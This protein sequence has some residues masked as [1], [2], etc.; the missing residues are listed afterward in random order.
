MS[1]MMIDL[2]LEILHRICI[3]L[4]SE[5]ALAFLH[6]SPSIH[7]ACN[8]WTVWRDLIA[9][10]PSF[11][12]GFST[13]TQYAWKRYVVADARASRLEEGTC[14]RKAVEQYLPQLLA[15]KYTGAPSIHAEA[16]YNLCHPLI[17]NAVYPRSLVRLAT[18]SNPRWEFMTNPSSPFSASDWQSAQAAAFCFASR[19][20]SD[21][22]SP[23]DPE[24]S[25]F[26]LGSV[27][28]LLS[29]TEQ[30]KNGKAVAMQHALANAVVGCFCSELR[31]ALSG[32]RTISENFDGC[33]YPPSDV[34]I[35]LKDCMAL[36]VP[37]STR[38]TEM[39]GTCHV[40]AMTTPSFFTED[41]W[42][43][44]FSTRGDWRSVYQGVGGYSDEAVKS[45]R[46]ASVCE[47]AVE[48]VVRFRVVRTHENGDFVLR[49]NRFH[50]PTE[51]HV[52]TMLVERKTGR[53]T[54]SLDNSCKSIEDVSGSEVRNAV[55]TPFGIVH[56]VRPGE[57]MWLWKSRWSR[58]VEPGMQ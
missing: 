23:E 55:I 10:N 50:T 11:P 18:D 43:G 29:T 17:S 54:A 12:R 8:D 58:E 28:W 41:E 42:T 33:A 48:S 13:S 32:E 6:T 39:F 16:F 36:P 57:W 14:I 46:R 56:G 9:Q 47:P 45:G 35:P 4:P 1:T 15:L 37:F 30:T 44:Y 52:L 49:S 20:L 27:R 21:D 38:S 25:P 7:Q 24:T 53:L 2:P 19:V 5:S 31:I 22:T 3:Y 51:Q 26:Q 40:R 34:E